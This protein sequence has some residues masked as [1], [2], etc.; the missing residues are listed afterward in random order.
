[1]GIGFPT[2]P[3]R[4]VGGSAA[5]LSRSAPVVLWRAVG[6]RRQ[7]ARTHASQKATHDPPPPPPPPPG[8]AA[9]RHVQAPPIRAGDRAGLPSLC[10][11]AGGAPGTRRLHGA[12]APATP[13][14]CARTGT[15]LPAPSSIT[16]DSRACESTREQ[17][18]PPARPGR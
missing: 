15:A 8:R 6:A 18:K 4:P 2:C 17:R 5:W 3:I 1:M 13:I 11:A 14:E 16:F 10:A 12:R 7:T 9:R